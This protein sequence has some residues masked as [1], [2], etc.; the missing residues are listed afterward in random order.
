MLERIR[1]W[2]DRWWDTILSG[3]MIAVLIYVLI[4]LT[5]FMIFFIGKCLG[6]QC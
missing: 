6:Y 4:V 1:N 5:A 2:I 3:A